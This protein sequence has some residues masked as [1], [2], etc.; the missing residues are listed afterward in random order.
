VTTDRCG[1]RSFCQEVF[2]AEEGSGAK[3]C[4]LL[5]VGQ[6]HNLSQL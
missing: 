1:V 4:Q 6:V 5:V 3:D 2:L